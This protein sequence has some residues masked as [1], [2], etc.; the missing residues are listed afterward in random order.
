MTWMPSRVAAALV[1]IAAV[2]F[3]LG[4]PV[5]AR[6]DGLVPSRHGSFGHYTLALTWQPGFCGTDGG[7]RADQPRTVLIGL[8]GLWASRPQPLIA[9]GISAPQWWH[10]GCAYYQHSDRAPTLSGSI[11][12]RLAAVVPH[13]E[14]SLVRHEYDKHVQCF[15]FSADTFFRTALALRH[16]V[17][18]S[19]FGRYLVGRARGHRV[20]HDRVV[21][22]FRHAFDT[23][24]NAALQLRCRKNGKGRPVL[25]QI[26]IT[27][28]SDALR[29]FPRA[30][31]LMNAPIAQDD[32][33]AAFLVPTWP[34]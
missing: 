1:A 24:L 15:G 22:A 4:A 14:H 30:R 9:R 23:P 6:G 33:P 27:L 7:C 29:D 3:A 28:H 17:L 25:T 2:V 18:D 12:R 13:L 8:H 20:S 31:A 16:A 21:R 10:H 32:C 34:S 19:G 26:W 11:R 5:H